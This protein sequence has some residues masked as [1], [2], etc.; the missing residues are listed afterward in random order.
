M[1]Y[2]RL[3]RKKNNL[4]G[5]TFLY[6]LFLP[7]LFVFTPTYAQEQNHVVLQSRYAGMF[8]VFHDVLALLKSYEEGAYSSVEVDFAEGGLYYAPDHGSNWWSYYFDP[9]ILGEKVNKAIRSISYH[10]RC[11]ISHFAA[12]NYESRC[13]ARDLMEKY[14]HLKPFLLEKINQFVFDHFRDTYVI[15]IH[16]R[17]TDKTTEATPVSYAEVAKKVEEVLLETQPHNYTLFIATDEQNFLDYM[18]SLYGNTVCYNTEAIRSLNSIPLHLGNTDRY[19]CGIDAIVDAVLL[20]RSNYLI[21]MVSN[22]S[23]VS[24]FFNPNIPVYLLNAFQN[25][26][27]Y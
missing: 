1:L 26:G 22:L 18:I 24:T 25:G 27:A 16:Y 14:I 10:P 21:R 9:I 3:N 17:G 13:E 4:T 12:E 23:Q 6:Y 15:A 19:Q 2:Y 11:L 5:S 7:F 20:S 8:S